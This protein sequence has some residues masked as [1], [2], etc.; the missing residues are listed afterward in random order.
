MKRNWRIRWLANVNL[1]VD[2]KPEAGEVL[3]SIRDL[4]VKDERGIEQVNA[5]I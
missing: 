5:L 3:L 4:H 2:K 1:H